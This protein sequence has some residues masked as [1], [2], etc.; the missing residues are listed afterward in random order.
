MKDIFKE[1]GL[2]ELFPHEKKTSHQLDEYQNLRLA[3]FSPEESVQIIENSEN[4]SI[5]GHGE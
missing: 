1:F 3:G 2:D 5:L 4:I